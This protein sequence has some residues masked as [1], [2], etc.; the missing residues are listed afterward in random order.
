MLSRSLHISF[1]IKALSI[2]LLLLCFD[3]IG[4]FTLEYMHVVLLGVVRQVTNALFDTAYHTKVFYLGKSKLDQIDQKLCQFS[5]PSNIRRS[6]RSH[7]IQICNETGILSP[8]DA[9]CE[10]NSYISYK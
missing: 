6:P 7:S 9:T 3:I 1:G 4:G 5:P 2:L 10:C 8:L